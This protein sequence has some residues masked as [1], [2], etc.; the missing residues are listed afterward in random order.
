MD[1]KKPDPLVLEGNLKEN[2]AKFKQVYTV[3][4]TATKTNKEE[5]IVQVARFLSCA[6]DAAIEL[7]ETFQLSTDERK[8]IDVVIA[9]FEEY[10][11]PR[12]NEVY[13]RYLFYTRSQ[14]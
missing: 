1:F 7:F 5:D 11:N 3:Y 9:K 14:K 12:T 6:G 2:F 13:E 8:K 10:C 4:A